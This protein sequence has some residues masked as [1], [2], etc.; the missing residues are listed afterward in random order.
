M[1]KKMNDS[2][3]FNENQAKVQAEQNRLMEEHVVSNKKQLQL[4]YK[5]MLDRQMEV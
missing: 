4:Q 2:R 5:D 1:L 3:T